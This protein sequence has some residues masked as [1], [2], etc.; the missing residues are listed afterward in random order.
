M[1]PGSRSL[2]IALSAVLALLSL[3]IFTS[4]AFSAQ[5]ISPSSTNATR[6]PDWRT[7][8]AEALDY[9]RRYVQFDTT[10]P[11]SN[12]ADA[13]AYLKKLLDREG[14][15]NETFESKPG[16]VTLV[17]RIPGDVTLRPLLFM[18]HADVV[19]AAGGEWTHPPFSADLADGYVWGRGA[20][21]NKAHGIMALMTMIALKRASVRLRRGIE[22][23]INPDE[24]AGGEWGARWMVDN[25]FESID[26]AFAINEG[27]TASEDPFRPN[28]ADFPIAVSEKMPLWLHLTAK[29][30]SGHAS[31]PSPDNPNQ[32]LV[33][34]LSRLMTMAS[35]RPAHLE[36]LVA[37]SFLDRARYEPFPISYEL[38]HLDWPGMLDVASRGILAAPSLQASL[39]DTLTLTII[40]AGNKVNVIPSH[41]E[42]DVDCRLLPDT[43][44]AAFIREVQ[45][46]AGPRIAV[47]ARLR[48]IRA[49]PSPASGELWDAITKVIHTDFKGMG[50]APTMMTAVTDSRFLRARGIPVY[51]FLPLVLKGADGDGIHGVDERLSVENFNRGLRATYDLATEVCADHIGTLEA[52]R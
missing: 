27:G 11:P 16:M 30:V 29:G 17:A 41:A 34:G 26:P 15:E 33:E 18:S 8:D 39:R 13:I 38:T 14:I 35:A 3:A 46:A 7:L 9:F 43:D 2:F 37:Q 19:P 22:M 45:A 52:T 40:T 25:H 51:G 20:I 4:V 10:N 42:A 21:D 28:V 36:P 48:P 47:E 49:K 32:I 31:I 24:E 1:P 23:M 5:S 44:A 6:A 12:T 50:F